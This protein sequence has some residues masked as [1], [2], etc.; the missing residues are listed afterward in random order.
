MAAPYTLKELLAALES[1]AREIEVFF[2]A[3]PRETFFKGD[4][5]HW[6][7]AHHISHLTLA[8]KRAGR[9][10]A[11][12]TTLPPHNGAPARTLEQLS[13]MYAAKISQVSAEQLLKNPLP[14]RVGPD[15]VQAELVSEYA[16][17]SAD[18]REAAGK[19]SEADCDSRAVAHPFLGML[20]VREMLLFFIMHDRRHYD[21][22]RRRLDGEAS[23][24]A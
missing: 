22:V 10:F 18:L 23:R 2:R 20:S 9:A 5:I 1:G 8:Y 19:W 13:A 4:D 6:G 11:A 17:S 12:P 3:L 15:S 21:G 7:P 24:E 16:T 14:P